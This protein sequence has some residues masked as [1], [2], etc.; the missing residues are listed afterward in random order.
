MPGGAVEALARA[1]DEGLT[2]FV[3]VTGHGLRIARMHRLSLEQFPFD[4]VLLPVNFTLLSD[5]GYAADVEDLLAMC[6][7]RQ[8]AVQ[9]IKAIARRRWSDDTADPRFSWYEP[10]ADEAAIGRAVRY[11][12]SDPRLFLVTS[13][14]Y[15]QLPTTVEAASGPLDRPSDDELAA[16]VEAFGIA[17]IFDGDTLER[18]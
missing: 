2:R 18:I 1:R 6:E 12:L 16:D 17:P 4:S 7:R 10:L 14:D 5:P 8:V 11:V 15:R 9:T 3:G 13:S